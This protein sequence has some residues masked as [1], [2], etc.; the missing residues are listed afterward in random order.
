M[1]Q[2][3]NNEL[4]LEALVR[5]P[6]MLGFDAAS[7]GQSVAFTSNQ[8]GRWEIYLRDLTPGASAEPVCITAG[9]ERK[10]GP[11]FSPDSRY[12]AYLQ[13]FQ[14]NEN[15]DIFIYDTQ[16]GSSINI[17]NSPDTAIYPGVCWS[18]DG[19]TIG[20]VSNQDGTFATYTIAVQGGPVTRLTHHQFSDGEVEFSPDGKWLAIGAQTEGLD[21]GLFALDL[22]SNKIHELLVDGKRI[23]AGS[24]HWSPDSRTLVFQS[25]SKGNYEIG[26]WELTSENVRWLTSDEWDKTEPRFSPNGSKVAYTINRDATIELAVLNLSDSETKYYRVSAGVHT[27]PHWTADSKS[28]IFRYVGPRYPSG[29]WK[30]DLQSDAQSSLTSTPG[31]LWSDLLIEPSV[32]RY[33]SRKGGA[34][35]PAL[36]YQPTATNDRVAA[37]IYVH[38]GPTAQQL[39]GWAADI[40]YLVSRGFVVLC[41]NYRGSTGY[42]KTWQ[43]A[44]TFDMGMG[45]LEDVM[46]GIDFLVGQKLAEPGSIAITGGSYGGYMTMMAITKYPQVWAAAVS[47]VPF[48]NWFTEYEN[49]REDLKY[50]D[51]QMMGDPVKDYQRWF[52]CSPVN[53]LENITTPVLLL[54]G[55]HDPRCPAEETQQAIDKLAVLG[56]TFAAHIYPDEGHGFARIANRIDAIRRQVEFL[57]RYCPPA[58]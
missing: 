24:P 8:S 18:P 9:P 53:F 58:S 5:V 1:A 4:D 51:S 55:A 15:F 34:V 30:L 16:N 27:D 6:L 56:K 40:Q 21:G 23:D 35:V 33:P 7:D 42:G 13:D 48:L 45:D 38:G 12:I 50:Y 3:Q 26:L 25:N 11:R 32:V 41:P 52:D 31:S 46:G 44:N 54:A 14:G 20:F 19:Q 10:T 17:T 57:E 28:L 39:N 22:A 29:L 47:I 37:V 36:L 49:E 2:T 43:E